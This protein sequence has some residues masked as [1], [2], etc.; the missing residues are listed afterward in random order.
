LKQGRKNMTTEKSSGY[1]NNLRVVL[2]ARKPDASASAPALRGLVEIDG[3]K[4]S[5]SLW[6]N[7]YL[8]DEESVGVLN[9]ICTDIQDLQLETKSPLFKGRM[10]IDGEFTRQKSSRAPRKSA[11]SKPAAS[12]RKAR[13][14]EEDGDD[15]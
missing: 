6:V 8:D 4:Y 14:V 1:D 9:E 11:A 2:W 10:Q 15:W 12:K 3:V 13:Q 5:I 7:D